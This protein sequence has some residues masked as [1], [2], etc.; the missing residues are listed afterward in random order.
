MKRKFLFIF[1]STAI[2]FPLS[3]SAQKKQART[4]PKLE[5]VS[6]TISYAFG[7]NMVQG[8]PQYLAQM[9]VMVDTMS[10]SM[11]YRQ[12]MEMETDELAKAALESEMKAKLDSA[13]AVNNRNLPIFL[14]GFQ[15]A[16]NEDG[17]QMIYNSGVAIAGQVKSMLNRFSP[18]SMGL[19]NSVSL[20]EDLFLKGFIGTLSGEEKLVENPQEVIQQI[21][22]NQRQATE[23]KEMEAM[24]AQYK[25]KIAESDKFFA[26]N[27]KK[28]GIV[29]RPS[30]LQYKIERKGNG[31]IPKVGER[32]KVHYHGT[33]LDGTVF[34]SSVE[35]G[36]SVEFSVGQLI[37]GW[38]EALLLMP[39]GSK[40]T[41]YIPYD[42]AYNA[43]DQGII[44]PFS[45]L[46]FEVELIEVESGDNN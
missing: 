3:T 45:S 30:G 25:D 36:E 15:K 16:F 40:W 17:D 39:A 18:E 26:Q 4:A 8:L 19:D 28:K 2:L 34:D 6:D 35:R 29:T 44:K 46:I 23:Q 5:N 11:E 22:E 1:I 32:V 12:R 38:N 9:G 13:N 7:A 37:R 10:I 27:K 21:V 42:L 20:R 14:E 33:L 31:A 41:L 24:K 43:M